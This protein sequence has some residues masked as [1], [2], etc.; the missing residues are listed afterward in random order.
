M[1]DC[2]RFLLVIQV[3]EEDF[4]DPFPQV[5][6]LVESTVAQM[7]LQAAA[8]E[9]AYFYCCSRGLAE[10]TNLEPLTWGLRWAIVVYDVGCKDRRPWAAPGGSVLHA[11]SASLAP[12]LESLPQLSWNNPNWTQGFSLSSATFHPR[13][14][15]GVQLGSNVVVRSSYHPVRNIATCAKELPQTTH[16]TNK[17]TQT[18]TSINS[19]QP[20]RGTA[21]ISTTTSTSYFRIVYLG[22]NARGCAEQEQ[23]DK[24]QSRIASLLLLLY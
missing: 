15:S 19:H 11:G 22:R 7:V 23:H 20:A 8:K 18:C 4:H 10:E 21:A 1:H 24:R 13:F 9:L 2:F 12:Y 16:N 17:H 6:K 3:I 14:H 5:D